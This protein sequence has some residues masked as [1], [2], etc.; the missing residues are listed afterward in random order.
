MELSVN[1]YIKDIKI[2]YNFE[3]KYVV[4]MQ[5]IS[6]YNVKYEFGNKGLSFPTKLMPFFNV[7]SSGNSNGKNE[8]KDLKVR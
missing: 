1:D 8:D 4:K 7:G 6:K 5:I 3:E 2:F